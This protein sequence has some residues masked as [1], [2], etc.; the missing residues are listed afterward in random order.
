MVKNFYVN[1][2]DIYC[3][4]DMLCEINNVENIKAIPA[5]LIERES[6]FEH[7]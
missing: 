1:D 7:R 2:D 3:T 5:R 6:I 4:V